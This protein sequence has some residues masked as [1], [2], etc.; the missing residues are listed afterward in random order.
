MEC[1]VKY[2]PYLFLWAS[3]SPGILAA[4]SLA[5]SPKTLPSCEPM[6]EIRKAFDERLNGKEL[7]KMKFVDQAARHRAIYEE[8]IARYPREIEPY[9]RLIQDTRRMEEHLDPSQYP[10]LQERFRKQAAENPDDPLAL[11]VAG[12]SLFETDTSES[13]RLL[14]A[15]KT[16]APQFPWPALALA[17][18]YSTGKRVDKQK[19]SENLAAFFAQCPASTDA[20]AQWFLAT[21]VS[22]ERR[23]ATAL[24]ERLAKEADPARL[25]DY[26][27]L[28]GLEFRTRPPQ[29]HDALRQQVAEDLKRLESLNPKPD[30]AWQTFLISGYKQTGASSE[31]TAV[32]E[33]RLLRDYPRSD[34]AFDLVSERWQKAHNEPGDQKDAVG[35]AKYSEAYKQALRGWIHDFPDNSGI[36]HEDWFFAISD[37]DSLTEKDSTAAMDEYL[38]YATVY[39]SPNAWYQFGAADFLLKHKWQPSRA[40][41]LLQQAKEIFDRD[42]A[43]QRENDNLSAEDRDGLNE[44]ILFEDLWVAGAILKG[45]RL[46]GRPDAAMTIKRFVEEPPP[47]QEILQSTYWWNRARLAVLENHQQDALAYYQL[48][49]HTRSVTR[50]YS[51][52]RFRDDLADEAQALWKETGGTPAAW[53]VWSKPLASKAVE[54]AQGAWEKPKKML[55]AFELAD[56]SGKTWRLKDLGGKAVLITLWATWCG[57]C[58]EELPK[59]QRLYE[60]IKGRSD[61]QLLTFDIDEDLGLVAPYLR[62]KGYTFPVLPAYSLVVGMLDGYAIPQN[63]VVDPTGKWQWTQFG[64][65][66]EDNWA[67]VMMQ[68]L[69]SART[70][71]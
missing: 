27:T 63:W 37:E 5:Q 45:A 8:L 33:D 3:L 30:S 38:Q 51:R 32:M 17:G 28:W 46:A 34:E 6:P 53:A 26:G 14:E 7:E 1:K 43:L 55:P 25:K 48:S 57:P 29:E 61:I 9:R 59:L 2:K 70:S 31:A 67:E 66:A 50:L 54:Q 40:L 36:A 69:E 16:K 18:E 62:E 11:Y 24:R 12:V 52:G 19:S 39:R 56:L 68:K 44:T 47:T 10:A 13:L 71:N 58:K 21:D 49:L 42:H 4:A 41:D 35:W 15:A 64:Y 23:V 60:Q 20:K 22:L 65:G